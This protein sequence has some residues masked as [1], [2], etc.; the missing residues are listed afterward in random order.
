[1]LEYFRLLLSNIVF[2][3]TDHSIIIY[4]SQTENLLRLIL[5]ITLIIFYSLNIKNYYP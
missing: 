5:I 2:V 3:F 4:H 1:M